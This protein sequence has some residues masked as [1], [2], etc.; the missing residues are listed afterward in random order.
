MNKLV[1]FVPL[2]LTMMIVFF[3]TG[4]DVTSPDMSL[5]F[6]FYFMQD[7]ST[8]SIPMHCCYLKAGDDGVAATDSLYFVD[9]KDGYC[10]ARVGVQGYPIQ[11]VGATA[12]GGYALALC[13]NLLFYV[14]DGTYTVHA[15]VALGSYGEFILTDP[16]GGSWHLFSVGDD[17]TITTINSQSWDVTAVD[18]VD[19]L[20]DPAAA[21]ITSDGTA[22]FLADDDDDMIKKVSTG[23]LSSVIANCEVPGGVSDLCAGPGDVVYA[24]ADSLDEIWGIDIGTGQHY[25]TFHISE[26][27]IAVAVSPDGDYIYASYQNGGLIVINAQSGDIEVS[28][29]SYGTVYDI[30]VNG[31]G[32]RALICSN[33][34]KII[35]LEK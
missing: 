18:T 20:G 24:A 2:A 29:S 30:A 15:P 23:D 9:Y 31:S 13:G 34:D 7:I 22:I 5:E 12:E 10:V 8:S 11:D 21:A 26:P 28:S 27:A 19:G 17:G 35:T 14:S 3:L 16:T 1:V 32:N 25:D 33:L 6:P 4:C